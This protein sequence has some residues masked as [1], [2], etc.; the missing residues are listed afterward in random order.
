MIKKDVENVIREQ[1]NKKALEILLS[2]IE[3]MI[4]HLDSVKKS[5][6]TCPSGVLSSISTV[7]YASTK[8]KSMELIEL[9]RLLTAKYGQKFALGAHS[10]S[11]GNVDP[12]FIQFYDTQSFSSTLIVETLTD[13]AKQYQIKYGDYD[14]SKIVQQ[15][16]VEKEVDKFEEKMGSFRLEK[17]K[18][19]EKSLNEPKKSFMVEKVLSEPKKS[20]K[21]N[22]TDKS[23]SEEIK[24][25]PKMDL[26][27]FISSP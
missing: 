16:E 21:E 9:R 17:S 12:N 27:D 23:K 3:N 20:F 2:H 10:N 24:E 14:P 11:S 25:L 19:E 8:V 6:N 22:H 4:V 7:I 13:I 1:N 26:D 5:W 15:K 18:T